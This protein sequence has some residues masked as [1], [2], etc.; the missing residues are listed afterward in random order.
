MIVKRVILSLFLFMAATAVFSQSVNIVAGVVNDYN[1]DPVANA[2]I[3]TNSGDT[4]YT[5]TLGTFYLAVTNLTDSLYVIYNNKKSRGY[6]IPDNRVVSITL[7]IFLKEPGS[8]EEETLPDV[9]VQNRNHYLDSIQNRSDYAK[10]FDPTTSGEYLLKFLS[11]PIN[12]GYLFKTFQF[13]QNKKRQVYKDFAVFLEQEKH[14]KQRYTKLLMRKYT[15]LEGEELEAFMGRYAPS[16]EKLQ[17]MDDITLAQYVINCYK[18]Y[19]A[20]KK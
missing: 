2:V 6:S 15:D 4:A 1:F 3:H 11:N 17:S 8:A 19:Q 13:K 10:I 20:K 14:I 7:R 5:D 16:Y 9:V 12:I 18:Q